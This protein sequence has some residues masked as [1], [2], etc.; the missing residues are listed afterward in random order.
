MAAGFLSPVDIANRALQHCG[1]D[2]IFTFADPSREAQEMSSA[3]DKLRRA[4]LRRNCWRFAARRAWLW[5][6]DTTSLF[7]VP[8]AWASGTTYNRGD[9]VAYGNL[10]WVSRIASNAGNTPAG[11]NNAS[12]SGA[13]GLAW[14][15][16]FGSLN[17]EMW[18]VLGGNVETTNL[19]YATG[20]LVYKTPGDGTY[21]IYVSLTDNNTQQPD[22][23]DAWSA[24]VMYA[25]GA[26][27]SYNGT[28]YQSLVALNFNNE[29]DTSPSQWTTTITSA[30]VSGSW[31]QI[32][33]TTATGTPDVVTYPIGTGPASEINSRNIFRLPAGFLRKAPQMPS[34]GRVS[35]LGQPVGN[36]YTDWELTDGFIVS[37]SA[38]PI[39]FRF[40]A[41]VQDVSLF[42][43]MF[44]EGLAARL[45]LDV[46]PMLTDKPIDR[47]HIQRAYD[48][49]MF[50]ARVV[51]S[52]DESADDPPEDEWVT[53][54][55]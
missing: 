25:S 53:V 34:Y 16:Y 23:V 5:P 31:R 27:V 20:D 43:D 36:T 30:T 52:I 13:D 14:D 38:T 51:N 12:G 50:E 7:L 49:A 33:N 46:G 3:Y 55:I 9:M 10:Y 21:K 47:A 45:A 1:R 54:R 29:P 8:A 19:G 32:S 22:D 18:N 48:R 37:A 4:E 17:V 26:V 2:R 35:P 15:T 24:S 39:I 44:C 41:D 28:N 11:T 6:L 40:I 42:D